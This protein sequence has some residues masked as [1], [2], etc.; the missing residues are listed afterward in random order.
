MNHF[1]RLRCAA[2]ALLAGG[3]LPFAG[4]AQAP[5]NLTALTVEQA[6]EI[7]AGKPRSVTELYGTFVCFDALT[8]LTPDVAEVL[9]KIDKPLSFN[10][11]I[12]LSAET[13]AIL[14]AHPP[15]AKS[16]AMAAK[17]GRADLRL[18]GIKHL[19]APAAE[20]LAAHRGK[21]LL[22]SL[23][24][25]DSLALAQKM[26][27]EPGELRLGLKELSPAIAAELAQNR[28]EE[29]YRNQSGGGRRDGAPSILRLDNL[30]S[31]TP[32][33][34]EALASHEGVLVLNGLTTLDPSVAASLAKR[35]GNRKLGHK[36]TLALNGV[37]ALSPVAAAALATF[38]GELVLKGVTEMSAETAAALAKHEGRLHL[39][40]LTTMSPATRAALQSHPDVLLPR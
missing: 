40:G 14:A 22:H 19:S 33:A 31:L 32:E 28:G 35:V 8:T 1:Y 5:G 18:N 2:Q 21:V 25:L 7:A 23:E 26:S 10:G 13:A 3:L 34:A 37:T 12:E 30:E 38:P 39:T 6:R 11:L 4:F 29:V 9:V 20:A 27:C 16:G 17:T 15:A 24:K 36:G